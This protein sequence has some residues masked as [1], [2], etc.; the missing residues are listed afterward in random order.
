MK[1]KEVIGIDISKLRNEGCIHTNQMTLNFENNTKGFNILIKW[2]NKHSKYKPEEILYCFEHTGVYSFELAYFLTNKQYPFVLVP[3]LE[4]K[5][6]LGIQRVKNDK[7]DAARISLYAYRRKEEIVPSK[8]PSKDLIKIK[9]FLSAR[10]QLVKHRSGYKIILKEQTKVL[11]KQEGK[12]FTSIY[13]QL[14]HEFNEKIAQIEAELSIIISK[15]HQIKKMFDLITSIKGVGAQTALFIIVLTNGFESFKNAR[16][17]ASYAGI[18]PFQYE[19]GS[20]IKGKTKVSHLANKKIKALLSS[21]AI[22]AINHNAEIK[23]YYNRKIKEGKHKMCVI[24]AVRNKILA[25][26]FA[27]VQRQTPYVDTH[28]FAC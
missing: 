2:V 6:S 24:N 17:F 3:G 18:A 5:R 16:K 23:D 7:V 19:S 27:V 14:I 28:R 26:I 1:I 21:C 4:I 22:S 20:S 12:L 8:M 10:E 11:E 15:N 9:Y 13:K 25:R